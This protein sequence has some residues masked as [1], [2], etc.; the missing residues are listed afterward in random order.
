MRW[1]WVGPLLH[2]LLA[3]LASH[4]SRPRCR[5]RLPTGRRIAAPS[6]AWWELECLVVLGGRTCRQFA[7]VSPP[8]AVVH[9]LMRTVK[10]ADSLLWWALEGLLSLRAHAASAHE[11]SSGGSGGSF[12]SS[13]GVRNR[14]FPAAGARHRALAAKV[15][16]LKPASL[17]GVREE[18]NQ[19]SSGG[20]MS[21]GRIARDGRRLGLASI[22]RAHKMRASFLVLC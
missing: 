9:D 4:R 5:D 14:I 18:S 6:S 22:T 10:R 2:L 21:L 11:L 7:Q 1:C 3:F 12:Y 16:D 8:S 19:S 13:A 15:H 20:L 17:S